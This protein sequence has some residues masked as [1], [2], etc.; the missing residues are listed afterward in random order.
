VNLVAE[1]RDSGLRAI[2]AMAYVP[3]YAIK[4]RTWNV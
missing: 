3:F 2:Q 1:D 4:K